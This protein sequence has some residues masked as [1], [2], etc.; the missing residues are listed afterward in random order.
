M[1]QDYYLQLWIDAG[2]QP[3]SSPEDYLHCLEAA[4]DRKDVQLVHDLWD[5][6]MV[7]WE[8]EDSLADEH[9]LVDAM[10]TKLVNG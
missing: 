8:E 2:K 5:A 4:I 6:C 3:I 7:S 1:T 10:A 9:E